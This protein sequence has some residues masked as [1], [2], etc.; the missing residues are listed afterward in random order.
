MMENNLPCSRLWE[1][2][3]PLG[4][5]R[6]ERLERRVGEGCRNFGF[7]VIGNNWGRRTQGRPHGGSGMWMAV[8]FSS[9]QS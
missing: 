7:D 4:A 8:G 9:S 5:D 1:V 3:V 2:Y 6:Q